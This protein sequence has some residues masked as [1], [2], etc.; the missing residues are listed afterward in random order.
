MESLLKIKAFWHVTFLIGLAAPAFLMAVDG[1]PLTDDFT[2]ADVIPHK[3]A[4]I[5]TYSLFERLY[6]NFCSHKQLI[7]KQIF[8]FPYAWMDPLSHEQEIE[9]AWAV[10]STERQ[11]IDELY[12]SAGLSDVNFAEPYKTINEGDCCGY[13]FIR[14]IG[15]IYAAYSMLQIENGKTES[16]LKHLIKLHTVARRSFAHSIASSR[17]QWAAV[18]NQNLT[19]IYKIIQSQNYTGKILQSLITAFKPLSLGEISMTRRIN[20]AYLCDKYSLT[21]FYK[22]TSPIIR[23]LFISPNKTLQWVFDYYQLVNQGCKKYPPDIEAADE[24]WLEHN[25]RWYSTIPPFTNI[26][27][28]IFLGN[29]PGAYIGGEVESIFRMKVRSDLLAKELAAAK[30]KSQEMTDS[31][32]P[33]NFYL[34][35]EVVGQF[36]SVGKDCVKGTADDISI[37][38]EYGSSALD[39][40]KYLSDTL[41]K[42]GINRRNIV[43]IQRLVEY[44]GYR[45]RVFISAK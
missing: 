4:F 41:K 11:I 14:D 40:P 32:C 18:I 20:F 30:G 17:S 25:H 9:N 42:A 29:F 1:P 19:C 26:G 6:K 37:M 13:R 22:K 3:P 38:T 31:Y 15:K 44:P 2:M 21:N 43:A 10:I 45:L 36:V 8:R 35:N 7:D 23:N 24:F 16:G 39:G 28:E 34:F 33:Q 27:G 12:K 5:D